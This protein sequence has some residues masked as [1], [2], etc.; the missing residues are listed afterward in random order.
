MINA[1][2]KAEVK[3]LK[4]QVGALEA[5]SDKLRLNGSS[6]SKSMY[7]RKSKKG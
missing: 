5:E 3:V 7:G 4:E 2:L 1:G 6:M